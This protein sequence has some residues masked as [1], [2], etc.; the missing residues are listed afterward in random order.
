MHVDGF[1][2]RSGINLIAGRIRG[3]HW[4]IRYPRSGQGLIRTNIRPQ[5]WSLM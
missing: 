2:F 5:R 1:R 4:P 3:A